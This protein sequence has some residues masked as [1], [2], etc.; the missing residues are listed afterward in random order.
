MPA[1]SPPQENIFEPIA[2]SLPQQQSAPDVSEDCATATQR[3]TLAMPAGGLFEEPLP[4]PAG[5]G[6]DEP[7]ITVDVRGRRPAEPASP[8]PDTDL[9]PW[10]SRARRPAGADEPLLRRG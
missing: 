8:G 2:V 1:M 10:R 9:S 3:E 5:E 7:P 4:P 6:H